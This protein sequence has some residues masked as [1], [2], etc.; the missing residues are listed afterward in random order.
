VKT[1]LKMLGSGDHAMA[2]TIVPQ[3]LRLL[4]FP[5]RPSVAVGDKLVL[6]ALGHDRAFAIVEAF[7]PVRPGEGDN[8]WDRWFLDVRAV[9]SVPYADSPRLA[10][11]SVGGRQLRDSIREHSHITLRPGEYDAAVRLLHEAGAVE[12]GLYRAY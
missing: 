11:L 9:M 4:R 3:V 1:W 8:P 6:Y 12:D 5:R 2:E 10:E 7:L